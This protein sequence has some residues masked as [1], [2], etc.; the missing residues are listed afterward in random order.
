M[1]LED[2]PEAGANVAFGTDVRHVMVNGDLIVENGRSTKLDQ[3]KVVADII[4]ASRAPV[5]KADIVELLEPWQR[6][7]VTLDSR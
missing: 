3:E 4:Q 1:R 2:L 7:Y 5:E 6:P